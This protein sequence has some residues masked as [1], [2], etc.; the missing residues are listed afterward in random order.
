MICDKLATLADNTPLNTGAAGNY[1]VGDQM[2]LQVNRNVGVALGHAQ[3]Y[4]VIKV[5]Q[6]AS[7]GAGA[8]GTF[9][10]VTDDNGA[11]ASP[12]VIFSTPTFA[13]ADMTAGKVLAIVPLPISDSYER[14][15][16]LRQ[17]TGVAAFT[18]G[19]VDAFLTTSPPAYRAYEQG[20]GAAIA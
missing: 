5:A 10:L 20:D 11:L 14:Y 3:L 13:V 19:Q 9:D 15:V 7:G 12:N 4:L 17:R 2:D 6:T 16:G 8:T 18:G 1:I